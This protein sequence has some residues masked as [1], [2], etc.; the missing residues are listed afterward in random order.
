VLSGFVSADTIVP[1][2]DILAMGPSKQSNG[3]SNPQDLNRFSYVT[4]NPIRYADPTGHIRRSGALTRKD[5]EGIQ[6]DVG[7]LASGVADYGTG[8]SLAITALQ[9]LKVLSGNPLI[10]ASAT[11]LSWL[12]GKDLERGQQFLTDVLRA[13]EDVKDAKYIIDNDEEGHLIGHIYDAN[14]KL[15]QSVSSSFTLVSVN[16]IFEGAARRSDRY[17]VPQGQKPPDLSNPKEV[18]G[19]PCRNT[20]AICSGREP[21]W[22]ERIRPVN[23]PFVQCDGEKCWQEQPVNKP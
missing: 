10:G 20:Q 12:A 23:K 21:Y 8:G 3:P 4:N 19:D 14:G 9:W 11:A 16:V 15:L 13:S 5:I 17:I 22:T 18:I 2:A 1:S 7:N 6:D